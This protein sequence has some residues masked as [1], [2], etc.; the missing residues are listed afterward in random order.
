[1]SAQGM[2]EQ[3]GGA[4]RIEGVAIASDTKDK[5]EVEVARQRL[6]DAVEQGHRVVSLLADRLAPVSREIEPSETRAEEVRAA[7]GWSPL[8]RELY[9]TAD[10]MEHLCARLS[11]VIDRLDV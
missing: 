4:L 10:S 9:S 11:L 5:S 8:A 3:S 7:A 1:M 6:A 2:V